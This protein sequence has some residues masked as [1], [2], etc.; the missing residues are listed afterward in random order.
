MRTAIV[1]LKSGRKINTSSFD[2]MKA[3][4]Y[5]VNEYKIPLSEIYYVC[6]IDEISGETYNYYY[7]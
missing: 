7:I 2:R 6:N 5:V 3:L 4:D 1:V